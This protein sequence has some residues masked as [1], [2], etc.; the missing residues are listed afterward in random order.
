MRE[1][2][3]GIERSEERV[4]KT[5]CT[6]AEIQRKSEWQGQTQVERDRQTER[7]ERTSE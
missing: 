2:D 3:R 4:R 5:F 7:E 6:E 1:R